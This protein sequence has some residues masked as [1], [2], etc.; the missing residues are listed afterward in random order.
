MI[1][2]LKIANWKEIKPFAYYLNPLN[3]SITKMRGTLLKMDEE[4]HLRRKYII[5]NNVEL[6]TEVKDMV[7]KDLIVQWLVGDELKQD[8]FKFFYDT[9]KI[10]YESALQNKLFEAEANNNVL[11]NVIP[12][13]IAYRSIM[14]IR[15]IQLTKAKEIKKAKEK[16]EREGVIVS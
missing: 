6:Q 1:K 8:Q 4:G 9:T 10:V 14:V 11:E 15:E 2:T 13:L 3:V 16:A 5:E 12:K 7:H